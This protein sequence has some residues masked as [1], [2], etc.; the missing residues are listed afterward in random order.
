MPVGDECAGDQ[1]NQSFDRHCPSSPFGYRTHCLA[2]EGELNIDLAENKLDVAKYQINKVSTIMRKTRKCK[3]HETLKKVVPERTD[4]L[5][6]ELAAKLSYASC[7]RP[8][9]AKYHRDCMQRF[10]SGVTVIPGPVNYKHFAS[11]KNDRFN[12]FCD[13]HESSSYDYNI[14]VYFV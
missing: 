2:C 9:E 11:S 4:L 6:V 7:I 13:W 12:N 5:A 14:V 10:L 1:P 8:E 3:L